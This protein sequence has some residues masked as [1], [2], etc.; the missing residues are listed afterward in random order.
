MIDPFT[1]VEARMLPSG[2]LPSIEQENQ[3]EEPL[4]AETLRK[5][6]WIARQRINLQ[7]I[8]AHRDDLLRLAGSLKLGRVPATGI[9]RTLQVGDRP[10]R[11][12][13]ALET[14]GRAFGFDRMIDTLGAIVG[15]A[16]ATALL[17]ALKNNYAQLFLLTLIPGLAVARSKPKARP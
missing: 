3:P 4:P 15:P 1:Y 8:A 10:T 17:I 14:Y 6:N 16:A 13:Q 11:L 5:L 9:M 2:V 12:A 7:L